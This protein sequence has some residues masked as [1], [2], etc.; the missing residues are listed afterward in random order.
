[1][2]AVR[3]A[4]LAHVV[5]PG[6]VVWFV[7]FLAL[8]FVIPS[9]R[10]HDRMVWLWTALAGWVLGLIGLSIYAWQRWAARRGTRGSS[11]MALDER[12]GSTPT[13][14]RPH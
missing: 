6:T 3:G 5:V 8:L 1:L 13:E 7:L 12:L 14:I 2:P 4:G 9:L 11:R 10:E